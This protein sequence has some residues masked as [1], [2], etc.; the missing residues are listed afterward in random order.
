MLAG[1]NNYVIP[2]I[3]L[4]CATWAGLLAWSNVRQ[5]R[6][7]IGLLRALGKNSTG[8]IS[9]LL[10]KALIV[11]LLGGILGSLA[12]LAI[13]SQL[14]QSELLAVSADNFQAPK[15]LLLAT[16]GGS[17]LLA[18]LASYLPTLMAVQQDPAVVLM[19]G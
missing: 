13:A 7:E 19:D 1:L 5:R 17:P 10:G 12:G 14:A 9:L 15:M 2:L 11:G 3:V 18:A 8:I 16:I 6:A 4:V